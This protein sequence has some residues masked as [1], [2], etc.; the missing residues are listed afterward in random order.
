[1]TSD[2]LAA[3]PAESLPPPAVVVPTEEEAADAYDLAIARELNERFRPASN[4]GRLNVVARLMF[5]NAGGNGKAGGR[6]GGLQVD[7]GQSWNFIGY[8]A[9]VNV[10]LGRVYFDD[11]GAEVN[12]LVGGGPT[13]NL[14]R[15]ALL[16]RGYLDLRIGYDFLYGPVEQRETMTQDAPPSNPPDFVAPHGPRVQLNLGLLAQ[17]ALAR[18]FFQGFGATLGYQGLVGNF[19][20]GDL[21]YTHMLTIGISYWLG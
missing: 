20:G 18:K 9:T 21:P 16:G 1:V 2:L 3:E 7:V 4:P 14:G 19:G 17:N 6:L 15:L 10:W 5:A 12:A 11:Y 13:L 8:A